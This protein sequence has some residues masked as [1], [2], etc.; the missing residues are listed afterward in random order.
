MSFVGK[1][2]VEEGNIRRSGDELLTLI[3]LELKL[4]NK[5]LEEAFE[6][7]ITNEDVTDDN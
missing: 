7:N 5:R 1:E 6:T 3:Y 4:M 2:T